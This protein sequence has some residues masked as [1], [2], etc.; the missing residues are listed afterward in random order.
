MWFLNSDFLNFQKFVIFIVVLLLYKRHRNA[1][2]ILEHMHFRTGSNSFRG[3]SDISDGFSG[4]EPDRKDSI[5]GVS[6]F[7]RSHL[8]KSSKDHRKLGLDR[9]R[10]CIIG[11]GFLS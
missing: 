5:A 11:G 4:C 6:S 7:Q 8:C 10:F 1:L 9:K 2:L 3:Y